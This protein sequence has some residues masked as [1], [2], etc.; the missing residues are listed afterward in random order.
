[1]HVPGNENCIFSSLD[2]IVFD[3]SFGSHTLRQLIADHINHNKDL[4]ID[5][6]GGDFSKYVEK[7]GRMENEVE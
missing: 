2:M 5:H 6:I 1:M 3:G 4:F 7:L